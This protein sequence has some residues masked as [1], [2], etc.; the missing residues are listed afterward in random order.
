MKRAVL[1]LLLLLLAGSVT[2]CGWI[3]TRFD[4]SRLGNEDQLVMDYK[5]LNQTDTQ[6]LKLEA[7]DVVDFAIVSEWGQV[8]LSLQKDG[9]EAVYEKTNVPTSSFQVAIEDSGTYLLTVTGRHAKGS[10]H[11]VKESDT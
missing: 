8:D 10:V 11:I 9:E 2:A 4:G 5:V 7:G 3:G 6:S 1:F